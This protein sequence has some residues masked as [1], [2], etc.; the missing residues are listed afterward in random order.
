MSVYWLRAGYFLGLWIVLDGVDPGGILLGAVTALAASR[1]S[2]FLSPPQ[3]W[4][5][6]PMALVLFALRFLRQSV[7]AGTDIAWRA[8]TPAMPLRPGFVLHRTGLPPGHARGVFRM[9]A[10]LLPGSLPAGPEVEN[11]V[12]VHLL[13]TGRPALAE[14]AAEE[15]RFTW[16]FGVRAAGR[17]ASDG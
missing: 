11:A 14:L 8:L 17:P 3:G 9:L 7:I 10:S 1:I 2:L 12:P 16:A 6:R 5:P 4:R 15:A 13:D